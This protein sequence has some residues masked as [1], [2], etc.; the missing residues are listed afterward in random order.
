MATSLPAVNHMHAPY[1]TGDLRNNVYQQYIEGAGHTIYFE[2]ELVKLVHDGEGTKVTGAV[3]KTKD[4]Y[5]Q[6][7]AAESPAGHRRL[8][9]QSDYDRGPAAQRSP[10][11]DG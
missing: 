8:R 9:G 11:R 3:F 6:I 2:H 10:V 5:V 7:N 4:G 1:Y